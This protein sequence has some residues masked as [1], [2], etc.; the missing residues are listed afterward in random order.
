M[1]EKLEIAML[2]ANSK[3]LAGFEL[4]WLLS[5]RQLESVFQEMRIMPTFSG[6]AAAQ[7]QDV[8]LPVISLEQYYGLPVT[9]PGRPLK[10]LVVRSVG[11]DNTLVRLI[12][13]TPCVLRIDQVRSA[14]AFS[15]QLFLPENGGDILGI[16]FLSDRTLGIV[17][18]LARISNTVPG[19]N[20]MTA[21]GKE[22]R[23]SRKGQ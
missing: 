20:V 23:L 12:L 15:G 2:K 3:P 4:Y 10:Y 9:G 13:Q 18:D 19:R 14:V 17:P 6:I 7:Y 1:E 16:Y 11:N 8:L 22:S 21:Q 5:R